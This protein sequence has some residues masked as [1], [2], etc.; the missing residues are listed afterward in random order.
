MSMWAAAGPRRLDR[1][2]SSRGR[3]GYLFGVFDL[4]TVGHLDLIRQASARCDELVVAVAADRLVREMGAPAPITPEQERLAVVAAVRGV[5]G[6]ELLDNRDVAASA[7]NAGAQLVFGC[8]HGDVVQRALA[9][10]PAATASGLPVQD[11]A[12]GR[13]AASAAVDHAAT[14]PPVVA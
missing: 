8:T 13:L 12:P 6:A 4:L 1:A 5:A 11:L 14:P 10:R 2:R 7:R 3:V 9:H